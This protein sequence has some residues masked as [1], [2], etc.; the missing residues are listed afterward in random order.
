MPNYLDEV[1]DQL[2]ALTQRGAHRRRGRRA[3]EAIAVGALVAVVAVVVV[4]VAG[5]GGGR[6]PTPAS[7]RPAPSCSRSCS[8]ATRPGCRYGR[9]SAPPPCSA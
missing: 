5:T 4:A 8:A 3:G 2:V 7:H 1:E 9:W 6:R